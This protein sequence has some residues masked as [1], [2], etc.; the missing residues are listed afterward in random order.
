MQN[1]SRWLEKG[2]IAS[3]DVM[4][5]I[6]AFLLIEVG[7]TSCIFWQLYRVLAIFSAKGLRVGKRLYCKFAC[8]GFSS[9]PF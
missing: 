8:D 3:L 6:S 4:V 7:V 1:G 9:V 5:F 2:C